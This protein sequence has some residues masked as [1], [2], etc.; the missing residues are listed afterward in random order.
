MKVIVCIDN[1]NGMLFNKRRQSSDAVLLKNMK[2]LT[3]GHCLFISSFSEKLFA[4]NGMHGTVNDKMLEEAG[5]EDYCFVENLPLAPY[6]NNI[7]TVVLY[8]WN[9]D[10]P[11]DM[12]LDLDL[13]GWT[14]Q[15]TLE[16]VG[17]SHEKITREVYV[18]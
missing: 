10:Y 16:F 15:E 4:G 6:E 18:R 17:K 3:K 12:K 13:S 2:L 7:D 1:A 5:V 11:S 8:K 14:L 9:R